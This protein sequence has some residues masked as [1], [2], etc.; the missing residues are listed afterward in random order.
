MSEKRMSLILCRKDYLI[1]RYSPIDSQRRVVPCHSTLTLRMIEVITLILEYHLIRQHGKTVGEAAR[2]EKLTAVI[3][4]KFHCN[5]LA[6]S[7]RPFPDVDRNIEDLAF[8][9][10]DEFA[11]GMRRELEMKSADN[12]VTRLALIVLN[13][14]DPTDLS[15]KIPL[16]ERLEE[17]TSVVTEHLGFDDHHFRDIC[18]Y[19]VHIII[20]YSGRESSLDP[21]EGT[22]QQ[23]RLRNLPQLQEHHIFRFPDVPH[24]LLSNGTTPYAD[25]K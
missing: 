2:D 5:M 8:H 12:S 15:I 6:E 22:F 11:L 23:K 25:G 21:V 10:P 18:C 13:E 19:Y 24:D 17:I 9:H 20:V 1:F 7:R 16:R 3:L 14:P 4:G